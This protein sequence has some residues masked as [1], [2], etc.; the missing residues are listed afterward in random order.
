VGMQ[1]RVGGFEVGMEWDAQMISLG[2]VSEEGCRDGAFEE[3]PVDVFGWESWS[4]IVEKWVYS[5]DDRNTV[6]VWVKGRLVHQTSRYPGIMRDAT[7]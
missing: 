1:D 6:A 3:G 7:P 2:I 5:G 4:D